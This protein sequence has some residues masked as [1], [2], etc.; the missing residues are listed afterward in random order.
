MKRTA[1]LLSLLVF[2]LPAAQAQFV[3][4]TAADEDDGDALPGNGAGTSLR[5][6]V[7]Y[8]S[9]GD[10]ITFAPALSGQTISVTNGLISITKSVTIDAS[11]LVDGVIINGMAGTASSIAAAKPPTRST[12]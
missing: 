2:A 1:H 11:A 8:A 7:K 4:T 6:A 9:P 5:E 3:V 12:A 10:T